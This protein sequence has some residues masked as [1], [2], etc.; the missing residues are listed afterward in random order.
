MCHYK[1]IIEL[2]YKLVGRG[3]EERMPLSEKLVKYYR[4]I[5]LQ[6]SR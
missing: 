5:Q 2:V 6:H 3:H 4:K 1:P